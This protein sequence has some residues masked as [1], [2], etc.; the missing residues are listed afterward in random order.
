[1]VHVDYRLIFAVQHS[2]LNIGGEGLASLLK[3][4]RESIVRADSP[5]A[6]LDDLYGRKRC[7]CRSSTHGKLQVQKVLRSIAFASL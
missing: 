4:V 1:M 2:C 6:S 3:R 7:R 5:E